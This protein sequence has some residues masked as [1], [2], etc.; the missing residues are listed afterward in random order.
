M[1][2]VPAIPGGAITGSPVPPDAKGAGIINTNYSSVKNVVNAAELLKSSA[3]RVK[4]VAVVGASNLITDQ[5]VIEA[6]RQRF[7]ELQALEGRNRVA[8]EKELYTA[9]LRKTIE[10]ELILDEMYGKLKKAG[11]LAVIEEIKE[12]ASDTAGRQ[13]REIGKFY[14]VKSEDDFKAL[15]RMQG[16]T[17]PVIRRQIERQIMAD[18]YVGSLLKEKG[19]RVGLSEMREY[20]DTHPQEF[21]APDRVKWQHL[22]VSFTKHQTPQAAFNHAE[23][24]RQKASAGA[25]FVALVKQFDDGFAARQN[26]F[27][28][29]EKRG[30]IQPLDLESTVWSLKAGQMSAVIQTPTGYHLV[31]VIERDYAGLRPFDAKV[32]GEVREKL[33]KK[34]RQVEYKKLV[35]VLW[36]KG[37]VRVFEE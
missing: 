34:L 22:F 29:G 11:K 16:L 35:E 30:E 3:P 13:L 9:E 6:V 14:R 28:T 5:E 31:K 36:R 15:L 27:G 21:Q 18:Q 24:I 25:D 19:H 26:G 10:R 17:M 4:V 1:G 12:F 7:G 37:V 23:G 33:N 2:V 8:K 20:Y 32:Q